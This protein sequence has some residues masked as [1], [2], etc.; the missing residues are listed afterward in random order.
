MK[1]PSH[2]LKELHEVLVFSA[3]T[4]QEFLGRFLQF[5][6]LL[7]NLNYY[8][9]GHLSWKWYY[10]YH[11]GPF[12]SD[13]VNLKTFSNLK[14]NFDMGKPFTPLQQLLAVLPPQSKH[15]VPKAY[16]GNRSIFSC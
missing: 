14:L 8:Y 7:W 2:W 16:Q 9:Q 10:G 11:V 4:T 12:V 15:L 13:L 6:G 3:I 1:L 5:L